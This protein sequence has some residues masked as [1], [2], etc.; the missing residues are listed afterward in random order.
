MSAKYSLLPTHDGDPTGTCGEHKVDFSSF[1]TY[2]DT[3]RQSIAA[4]Y[5][6]YFS[7]TFKDKYRSIHQDGIVDAEC[8]TSVESKLQL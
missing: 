6:K 7:Y 3:S 8:E 5:P 4:K 2:D 1:Y